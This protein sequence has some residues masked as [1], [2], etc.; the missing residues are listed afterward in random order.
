MKPLMILVAVV[1]AIVAFFAFAFATVRR[2]SEVAMHL[3][4]DAEFARARITYITVG[5]VALVLEL[6]V[7]SRLFRRRLP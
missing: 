7:L 6:F 2:D 5:V 3:F 1:L 4:S